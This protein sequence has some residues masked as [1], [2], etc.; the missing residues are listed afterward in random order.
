M[1]RLVCWLI[2]VCLAALPVWAEPVDGDDARAEPDIV[3][4]FPRD[5]GRVTEHQTTT[6]IRAEFRIDRVWQPLVGAVRVDVSTNY[7]IKVTRIEFTDTAGEYQDVEPRSTG[8]SFSSSFQLR[9][10]QPDLTKPMILTQAI[11]WDSDE[12]P[13]T[14]LKVTPRV[15][16][17]SGVPLEVVQVGFNTRFRTVGGSP[18]VVDFAEQTLMLDQPEVNTPDFVMHFVRPPEVGNLEFM[19]FPRLSLVSPPTSILAFDAFGEDLVAQGLIEFGDSVVTARGD[20]I[21]PI[22]EVSPEL[23][24]VAEFAIMVR[25]VMVHLEEGHSEHCRSG[26]FVTIPGYQPSRPFFQ[27]VVGRGKLLEPWRHGGVPGLCMTYTRTIEDEAIAP[28]PGRRRIDEGGYLDVIAIQGHFSWP[29][30]LRDGDIWLRPI[31]GFRFV[32]DKHTRVYAEYLE[33]DEDWNVTR[34]DIGDRVDATLDVSEHGDLIIRI[35]SAPAERLENFFVC[36]YIVAPRV[37]RIED[38]PLSRFGEVMVGG[39]SVNGAVDRPSRLLVRDAD[40]PALRKDPPRIVNMMPSGGFP[41]YE[42]E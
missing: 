19:P 23:A 18:R 15:H 28:G 9:E 11:S 10:L 22:F 4:T 38:G 13:E 27:G 14:P 3:L 17:S 12:P 29:K 40:S 30:W 25:G 7:R 32:A 24:D 21:I 16:S 33:R 41:E 37:E 6:E 26:C 1:A 42:D 31:S 35:N 36:L 20:L 2:F 5:Q 34:H 8:P 39:T